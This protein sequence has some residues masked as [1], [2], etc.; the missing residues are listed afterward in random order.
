M[1]DHSNDSGYYDDTFDEQTF[2]LELR[3]SDGERVDIARRAQRAMKRLARLRA[4]NENVSF[5]DAWRNIFDEDRLR[6]DFC[7]SDGE[8]A[9]VAHHVWEELDDLSGYRDMQRARKPDP[10]DEPN[11]ESQRETERL[12]V[13]V[14]AWTEWARRR[15]RETTDSKVAADG[16]SHG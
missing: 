8:R 7:G 13:V 1:P 15:V 5:D 3:L 10:S 9:E 14:R 11:P 2:N 6:A 12:K 4:A 16:V